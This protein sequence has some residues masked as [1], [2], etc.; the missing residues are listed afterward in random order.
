MDFGIKNYNKY[1]EIEI[2]N[3]G[4]IFF[5]L[6]IKYKKCFFMFDVTHKNASSKID[7]NYIF[8]LFNSMQSV[9]FGGA[10]SYFLLKEY[11]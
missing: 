11:V 5:D 3:L 10:A 2:E 7:L 4:K 1:L 6:N 9:C 8:N